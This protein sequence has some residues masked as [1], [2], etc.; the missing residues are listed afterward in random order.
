MVLAIAN[1]YFLLDG[2]LVV[3]DY[4]EDKALAD[5]TERGLKPGDPVEDLIEQQQLAAAEASAA[6]GRSV[7]NKTERSGL[8]IYRTGGPTTVFGGSGLGP[9][10]D[11]PLNVAKKAMLNREGVNEEN[12]MLSMAERTREANEEWTK[13]R[14]ESLRPLGG[15]VEVEKPSEDKAMDVDNDDDDNDRGIY[16]L[17]AYEPHSNLVHCMFANAVNFIFL[18]TVFDRS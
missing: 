1:L 10:S 2:R 5:I 16:P 3:D 18:L 15:L 7:G 13:G 4:Y 9:F 12:W 6:A 8:G 17:G 11:G 14:K